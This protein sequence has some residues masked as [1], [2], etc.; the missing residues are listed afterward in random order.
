[1][2]GQHEGPFLGLHGRGMG[3]GRALEP[4][5]GL[6][7]LSLGG[8]S[9][10]LPA[11]LSRPWMP[12]PPIP[13]DEDVSTPL[14]QAAATGLGS[15]MPPLE[16]PGSKM[17]WA[18]ADSSSSVDGD[19]GDRKY[20]FGERTPSLYASYA[21]TPAQKWSK[22][23]TPPGSPAPGLAPFAI[24][25]IVAPNAPRPTDPATIVPDPSFF[26][27]GAIPLYVTVPVAMAHCCPHCGKHFAMAPETQASLDEPLAS[28]NRVFEEAGLG[29]LLT[30]LEALKAF[31]QRGA[32]LEVVSQE[33]PG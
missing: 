22:T 20:S 1:M 2:G 26:Q 15:W 3:R 7:G 29:H 31:T 19:L 23:P 9:Q 33:A 8:A 14:V 24:S 17:N 4:P 21:P 27:A 13:E 10:K 18:D 6:Q 5:P 11:T 30:D 32:R 12:G 25:G 16:L 28:L